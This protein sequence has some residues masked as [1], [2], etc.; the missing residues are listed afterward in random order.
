[1]QIAHRPQMLLCVTTAAAAA[2]AWLVRTMEQKNRCEKF[3]DNQKNPLRKLD[4]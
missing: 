1:M 2:A 4:N 3:L